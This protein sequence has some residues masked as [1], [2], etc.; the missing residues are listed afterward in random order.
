M[1]TKYDEANL[2]ENITKLQEDF[3]T[4]NPKKILFNKNQKIECADTIASNFDLN[5][6]YNKTLFIIPDKPII[7]FDY[8]VFKTYMSPERFDS[9]L[10]Y[11]YNITKEW[12][13]NIPNYELHINIQSLS[14]SAF[15]RYRVFFEKLFH[16]YPPI[17][18]TSIKMSKLYIYYTPNMIEHMLKF[19]SPF[20]SH[21]RDKIIFYS[22]QE[23]PEKLS[24]LLN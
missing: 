4:N 12:V 1:E 11:E 22:R 14:I 2:M 10:Q 13:D 15:E 18:P 16:K 3:Y 23:S 7:F 8:P 17:C 21:L 9:F 19:L 5:V 24:Q 6:L 20:I